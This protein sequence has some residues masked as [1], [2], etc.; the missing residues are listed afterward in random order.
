M[1]DYAFI[2]AWIH[3]QPILRNNREYLERGGH[4]IVCV[5]ELRVIGRE[6]LA[7]A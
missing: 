5:P 6:Q 3:A 1:P 7:A 2:L 4:F